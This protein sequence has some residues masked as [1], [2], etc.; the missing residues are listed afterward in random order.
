MD[1]KKALQMQGFFYNFYIYSS[2]EKGVRIRPQCSQTNIF[3][4]VTMSNCLCGGILLKQPPQAPLTT[5]TTA[6]PF[7]EF[8][9][10]LE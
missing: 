4:L 7:L 8:N 10:N 2:P 9:L 3:F 6:R 1:K 5:S